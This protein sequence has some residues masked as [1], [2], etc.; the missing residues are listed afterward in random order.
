MLNKNVEPKIV[1]LPI[2]AKFEALSIAFVQTPMYGFGQNCMGYP[3]LTMWLFNLGY[4]VLKA[5]ST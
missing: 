5:V 3:A 4:S 2:L 1:S